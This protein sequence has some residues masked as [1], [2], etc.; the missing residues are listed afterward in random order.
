MNHYWV[1]HKERPY[2]RVIA[3]ESSLKAR[4]VVANANKLGTVL[5]FYAIRSDLLSPE[6]RRKGKLFGA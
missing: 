5:D 3:E 6:E 1:F 4:Q 2:C